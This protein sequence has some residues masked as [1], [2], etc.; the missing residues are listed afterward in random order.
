MSL[1][2]SLDGPPL[3]FLEHVL[4]CVILFIRISHQHDSKSTIEKTKEH[5]REKTM[6]IN[7][8]K[9]FQKEDREVRALP[10]VHFRQCLR[11][12]PSAGSFFPAF[13]FGLPSSYFPDVVDLWMGVQ[14]TS[15]LVYFSGIYT[16]KRCGDM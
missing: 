16:P 14:F 8:P 12:Q 4:N 5:N 15:G 1:T 7:P 6:T 13:F 10:P 11:L 9:N 2:Q 3:L